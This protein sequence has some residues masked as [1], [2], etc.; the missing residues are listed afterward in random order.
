M[1][2]KKELWNGTFDDRERVSQIVENDGFNSSGKLRYRRSESSQPE[3]QAGPTWSWGP[4]F[5]DLSFTPSSTGVSGTHRHS[6]SGP[7]QSPCC[8]ETPL[9]AFCLL[10]SGLTLKTNPLR[11]GPV[12][13]YGR[14]NTKQLP[15]PSQTRRRFAKW[16]NKNK[17]LMGRLPRLGGKY[18]ET[19]W[20]LYYLIHQLY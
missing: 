20:K 17:T 13:P 9:R 12:A 11:A 15:T 7:S 3:A 8:I 2:K 19:I 10:V 6:D 5:Q 1:I 4:R 14:F 16:T 18:Q